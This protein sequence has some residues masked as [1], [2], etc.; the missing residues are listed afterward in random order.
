MS[1]GSCG[2]P[3]VIEGIINDFNELSVLSV[4]EFKNK[5]YVDIIVNT[6]ATRI[7]H[8][9]KKVYAKDLQNKNEIVLNYYTLVIT[10]YSY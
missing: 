7:E 1:Y 2:I 9:E 5:Y 8:L 10:N 3:Y 6:L 4:N